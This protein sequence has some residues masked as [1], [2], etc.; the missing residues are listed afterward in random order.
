MMASLLSVDWR[1]MLRRLRTRVDCAI[2]IIIIIIIRRRRRR[3][4][5]RH[6]VDGHYT[7]APYS[8]GWSRWRMQVL[9]TKMVDSPRF[10]VGWK[11]AHI[12][13][14]PLSA[15]N[16]RKNRSA[17]WLLVYHCLHQ[18][19]SL[20]LESVIT[21]S[22]LKICRSRWSLIWIYRGPELWCGIWFSKL[23]ASSRSSWNSMPSKFKK[24]LLTVGRLPSLLKTEL[25]CI[26][27]AVIIIFL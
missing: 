15:T 1:K 19:A 10:A 20:Y 24:S 3:F 22:L 4:V 25:L 2:I 9:T 18:L 6:N 23:L 17:V 11:T 8:K 16:M 5:R 27:S 13:F 12:S 26:S 7:S 21:Q 14:S